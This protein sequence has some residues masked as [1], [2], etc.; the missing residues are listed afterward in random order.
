MGYLFL[1]FAKLAGAA[2]MAAMKYAGREA[3]GTFNS[4]RINLIRSFICMGMS[5]VLIAFDPGVTGSHLWIGIVS[6]IA[7]A[8][9]MFTWILCAT[10]ASL[11]VVEI[12]MMFATVVIPLLLSP[13]LY[14]GETVT[15]LQWIGV[16]LIL[17]AVVLFAV[18]GRST[19]DEKK[20]KKAVDRTSVILIAVCMLSS[21]FVTVTQ[22]LYVTR[23]GKEY[24]AFFNAL[25]F[26]LVFIC[27]VIAYFVMRRI[28]FRK[29]DGGEAIPTV[30][31]LSG[32]A[33]GWIAVA[34]AG[35]VVYQFTNTL[36]SAY[37]PSAILY[38]LAY[39]SGFLLTAAMD[40]F[41]FHE[42]VTLRRVL[43]T[44]SAIAGSV[45]TVL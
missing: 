37:L 10:R 28:L 42:K 32:A 9:N 13:F 27:F 17:A 11:C 33:Y 21:T 16:V 1:L 8:V 4:I 36:A 38:P 44:L 26:I 15:L 2:K 29:S 19:A 12:F 14:V 18:P 35:M 3:T 39:G 43:G 24:T 31:K 23:V 5:V 20:D 41:L 25:T 6:G 30:N 40:T 34:A 22:K 7:N 45:L